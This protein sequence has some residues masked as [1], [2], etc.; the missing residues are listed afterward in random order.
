M[1]SVLRIAGVLLVVLMFGAACSKSKTSESTGGGESGGGQIKIGSD[2][3]NDHG[4]EAVSGGS[5]ELEA[6]NE[7]GDFYFKPTILTGTAGQKVTLEVKNEGDTEHNFSIDDQ[8]I[9]QDLEAGK[10]AE[11]DVTFP[12]SG[13]VEFY[14][15][16]H[17]TSGMAG[18]LKVS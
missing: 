9:D 8:T 4:T 13:V 3:A 12:Q 11:V 5:F 16:Y 14:C 17:R 1:R 2:T 18:E 6:D 7:E 15:K 10:S